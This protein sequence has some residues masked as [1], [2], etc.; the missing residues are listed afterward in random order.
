MKK[1]ILLLIALS[2]GFVFFS[3]RNRPEV[4]SSPILRP[5]VVVNGIDPSGS[6]GGRGWQQPKQVFY[7]QQV[8]MLESNPEGGTLIIFNFSEAVSN[9]IKISLEPLVVEPDVYSGEEMVRQVREKNELIKR[10]NLN[11]KR[12]FFERLECE[13][14]NYKPPRGDDYSYINK[15]L[16]G[17]T[18]TLKLYENHHAVV[19]LYTDLENDIPSSKQKLDSTLIGEITSLAELVLCNLSDDKIGMQIEIEIAT[20]HDFL[21]YLNNRVLKQ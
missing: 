18:K 13:L 21:Q 3:N 10:N 16:K 14:L 11:A 6:T 19:F 4:I 1:M 15:T 7:E 2:G 9:P 20:Y 8:A 12:V 5:L 17:I